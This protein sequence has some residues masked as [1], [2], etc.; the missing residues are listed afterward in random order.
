MPENIS[1]R[2]RRR[3]VRQFREQVGMT[4]REFGSLARISHPMLSQFETG[5]GSHN[6]SEEAWARLLDAMGVALNQNA[7]K[8]GISKAR[9]IA[10]KL[11]APMMVSLRSFVAPQTR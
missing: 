2:E 9:K 1:L 6:L 5:E 11:G 3:Y 8:A 10:D 4:L 7:D